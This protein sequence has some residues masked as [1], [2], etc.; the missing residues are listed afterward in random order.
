MVEKD[1]KLRTMQVKITS[2]KNDITKIKN[3][4]DSVYNYDKIIELENAIKHKITQKNQLE[5]EV[6]GM[7]RVKIEQER[8]LNSLDSKD[9]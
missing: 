5:T 7:G 4:L 2:Y 1:R 9:S 3:T 8:A 6:S